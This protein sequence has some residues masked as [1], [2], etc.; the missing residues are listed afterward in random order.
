M[1]LFLG[2]AGQVSLGL[3][4]TFFSVA[5]VQF[6]LFVV[7]FSVGAVVSVSFF[8]AAL[9]LGLVSWAVSCLL[10]VLRFY[11]VFHVLFSSHVSS[12]SRFLV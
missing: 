7:S 5:L 8:A 3:F 10:S 9:L 11:T 12:V 4:I 2:L 6:A 1:D